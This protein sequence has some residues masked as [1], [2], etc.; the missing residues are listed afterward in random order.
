MKRLI[1]SPRQST[2]I[3]SLAQETISDSYIVI[4]EKGK[5]NDSVFKDL[6]KSKLIQLDEFE[7]YISKNFFDF[8]LEKLDPLWF[9]NYVYGNIE[10]L[11][12]VV[13]VILGKGVEEI[14][15]PSGLLDILSLYI[16]REMLNNLYI[17]SRNTDFEKIGKIKIYV[18]RPHLDYFLTM[19]EGIEK[20]KY[21]L[22]FKA[23]TKIYEKFEVLNY[24]DWGGGLSL[25]YLMFKKEKPLPPVEYLAFMSGL[26]QNVLIKDEIENKELIL[27]LS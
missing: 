16:T 8:P 1:I 9:Y 23:W 3:T 21:S 17:L 5:I 2:F 24:F 12:E 15:L 25:Q 4:A 19:W 20:T 18:E 26:G 10:Y 13:K 11:F 22:M 14:Y 7:T 6:Y 27:C